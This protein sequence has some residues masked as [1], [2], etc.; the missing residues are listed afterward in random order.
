MKLK[1]GV[2]VIECL[3]EEDPGSEGHCLRNIF[4]L[5]EVKSKYSSV[6]SIEDLIALIAE[7][8]YKYIHVSAHGKVS[9]RGK[10]SGW[11]TPNGIGSRKNFT[12]YSFKSNAVAIVSTACMSGSEGFGKFIVNDLGAKYY[13]GPSRSPKF[14]INAAIK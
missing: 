13:I 6:N 8:R 10:F 9:A 7:S 4:R 1:D 2:E 11:W 5:M 14:Y 12:K 3:D